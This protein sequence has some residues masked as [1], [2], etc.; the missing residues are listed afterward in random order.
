VNLAL[1]S[2]DTPSSPNFFRGNLTG[3]YKVGATVAS[4]S[5]RYRF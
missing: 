3:S 1:Q 5:A 4:V 2:G